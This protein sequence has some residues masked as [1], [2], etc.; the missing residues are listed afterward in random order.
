MDMIDIRDSQSNRSGMRRIKP[1]RIEAAFEG[2]IGTWVGWKRIRPIRKIYS[3]LLRSHRS[4]I[5]VSLG[6]P[7]CNVEINSKQRIVIGNIN[8][9]ILQVPTSSKQYFV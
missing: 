1:Y 6:I 8:Q 2:Q 7:L 5:S 9:F 4:G 3:D